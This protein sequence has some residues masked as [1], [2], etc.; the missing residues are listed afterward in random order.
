MLVGFK[1]ACKPRS[2]VSI[3]TL[4]IGQP[5]D[6][7]TRTNSVARK[8]SFHVKVCECD[9]KFLPQFEINVISIVNSNYAEATMKRIKALIAKK[10]LKEMQLVSENVAVEEAQG[11]VC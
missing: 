8:I 4:L 5:T 3:E 6:L 10:T 7:D 9:Q 2:H 1:Q 11:Q